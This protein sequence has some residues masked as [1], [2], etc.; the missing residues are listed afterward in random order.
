MVVKFNAWNGELEYRLCLYF[1]LF[2]SK[3]HLLI[4][5]IYDLHHVKKLRI[6]MPWFERNRKQTSFI[7]SIVFNAIF[8]HMLSTDEWMHYQLIFQYLIIEIWK[9]YTHSFKDQREENLCFIFVCFVVIMISVFVKKVFFYN[10]ILF[11]WSHVSLFSWN[12]FV[13]ITIYKTYLFH[14]HM[15]NL[16]WLF[17][18]LTKI[19]MNINIIHKTTWWEWVTK[20]HSEIEF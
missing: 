9:K 5:T 11:N 19:R 20:Y 8:F 15:G 2:Q 3:W 12:S 4:Y 6:L 7:C 14:I 10:R 18:A 16:K 17:C 1:L 13:V